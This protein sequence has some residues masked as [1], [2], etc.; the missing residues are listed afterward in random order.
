[1]GRQES[2]IFENRAFSR[3]TECT[4]LPQELV[5]AKNFISCFPL[6]HEDVTNLVDI[7]IEIWIIFKFLRNQLRLHLRR[8]RM[9]A[10]SEK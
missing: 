7:S 2:H 8:T 1:M 6:V 5:S 9:Y 3:I 10:I 4:I